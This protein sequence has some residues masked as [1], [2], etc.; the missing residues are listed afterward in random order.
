MSYLSGGYNNGNHEKFVGAYSDTDNIVRLG[1][2]MFRFRPGVSTRI[3]EFAIINGSKNYAVYAVKSHGVNQSRA[4]YQNVAAV[5]GT[6]YS[7]DMEDSLPTDGSGRLEVNISSP[8]NN[9]AAWY[10]VTFW[11]PSPNK[12]SIF[13]EI[14]ESTVNV[15]LYE[16][17][18]ICHR[19]R[20]TAGD[21]AT[22][23]T[24]NGRVYKW[25]DWLP[26]VSGVFLEGTN[27]VLSHGHLFRANSGGYCELYVGSSASGETWTID[28]DFIKTPPLSLSR[29]GTFD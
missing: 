21:N 29:F 1:Q 11:A 20:I 3:P 4:K 9:D 15:D 12:I 14:L 17:Q 25:A 18:L 6:W 2:L 24:F 16:N 28:V 27:T 10:S 8:D 23:N 19:H 5:A 13:A 26:K 7:L 22:I